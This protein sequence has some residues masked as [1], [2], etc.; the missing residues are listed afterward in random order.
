MHITDAKVVLELARWVT[1]GSLLAT[2]QAQKETVGQLRMHLG[3]WWRAR[4]PESLLPT[5]LTRMRKE[6]A[7]VF[8]GLY[9]TLAWRFSPQEARS[10]ISGS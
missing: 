1:Q 6:L 3:D 9:G 8:A 7:D 2:A 4:K 10:V 5:G